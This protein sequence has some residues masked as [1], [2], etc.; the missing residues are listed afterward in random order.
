[1]KLNWQNLE[2]IKFDN[3]LKVKNYYKILS[4]EN[5]FLKEAK[6]NYIK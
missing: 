5:R 6:R 4:T 1:M 3:T 2:K